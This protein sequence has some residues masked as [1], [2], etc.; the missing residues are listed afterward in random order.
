MGNYS[1]MGVFTFFKLYKWYQI[2]KPTTYVQK[3][4]CSRR[5]HKKNQWLGYQLL[6]HMS[7]K[8]Q[9]LHYRKSTER[10]RS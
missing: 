2:G 1:S 7:K 9:K 6:G 3:L 8:K 10:L 5:S 4:T